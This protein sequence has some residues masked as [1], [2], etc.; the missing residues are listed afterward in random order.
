MKAI[1]K[2][3]LFIFVSAL[4]CQSCTNLDEEVYSSIPADQF[5]RNEEEV[6]MNV[7]R[8][9]THLYS[10]IGHFSLWSAILIS[11]DEAICPYRETN[12][13]WDNGVWV[14][15]HRHNFSSQY[16]NTENCWSFIFDGI[17]LCNQI[18]YQLDMS[19]V[20]FQTKPN[21]ISEVKILRAWLYFH[22]LDIFGNVPLSIDFAQQELPEQVSRTELFNFIDKEINENVALLDKF[23]TSNNYGRV[24]QSMAY[25]VQAK[26]YLN[27][28]EWIGKEMWNETIESC[29]KIIAFNNFILEPD[30]FANFRINNE[31][32]KENIFVMS[33]DDIYTSWRMIFHQLTLHTLSQQTFGIV[34]FCWD[35]FCAM[36]DH[37][38]LYSESD[39]RRR[40]WLEGPQFDAAGNPLMLSPTRQLTYRPN[41]KALYNEYDPALLDDGVRFAKYEFES[42]LM[43]GMSNDFV[44]FRYA[45]I[46]LMKAEALVRLGKTTESLPYLNQVRTRAEATLYTEKDVTLTE[47]L[48]ER[49]RELAWEGFRRQDLIRFGKWNDAWF[50]KEAK[51]NYTKLF[52]IPYWAMDTNSKLKQNPGY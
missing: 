14:N 51:D 44:F 21:L 33:L 6:I 15:L 35:G 48:D 25:T 28:E 4:F 46:L 36:E 38:K 9:Y 2:I 10:Y 43:N 19:N 20:D 27:A 34:D 39:V 17:T 37:Y 7:G 49:S 12:L 22:A 42:G 30:F 47:I 32:S 5:F 18:L 52:P 45:D 8:A 16:G 13:W 50:D 3:H 41:V 11:S 29:D 23:P 26:L 24:T 1:Y 31:G 40:G